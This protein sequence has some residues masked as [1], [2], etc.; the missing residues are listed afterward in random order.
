MFHAFQAERGETRYPRDLLALT[1]PFDA[2]NYRLKYE[3]NLLL[4]EAF[5]EKEIGRKIELLNDICGLRAKRAEIIGGMLDCELL[6][7]TAEGMAE[8]VGCLALKELSAEKF[9]RLASSHADILKTP[10]KT[11]FDI[12][13]VSYFSGALL[14]LTA[15]DAGLSPNH[16]VGCEK[17]TVFEIIASQLKPSLP[18]IAE[19]DRISELAEEVFKERGGAIEAFFA[20]KP[21]ETREAFS[22]ELRPH[23]HVPPRRFYNVRPLYTPDRRRNAKKHN[24]YG[25]DAAGVEAGSLDRAAALLQATNRAELRKRTGRAPA[26]RRGRLP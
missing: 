23:E 14:L 6:A 2:R 17:R 18:I 22:S 19:D 12:R 10:N 8:Y 26:R 13:R 7:E 1:Y 20:D 3:E 25:P 16:S 4:S 15:I 5:F 11:Q 9:G 21:K 24:A